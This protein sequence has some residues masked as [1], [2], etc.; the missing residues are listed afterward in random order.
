MELKIQGNMIQGSRDYQEDYYE[1]CTEQFKGLNS[2]LVVLCDGMGGHSGGALASHIVVTAFVNEFI[3]STKLTP[4]D[5]LAKSLSEAQLAIKAEVNDNAAPPDMGTTL[6]AIYV[7]DSDLHWLSVGDSHL[8]FYR[9][10][11]VI[12]LNED[13]SMA[14]VLDGLVEIGRLET[15]E[16]L[17]D[18]QRSAL[19]SY[20]SV[21][22][23]PLVDIQS[24]LNYLSSKDKLVLASDGLDTITLKDIE[25]I[26]DKNKNKSP[27]FISSKLLTA[28]EFAKAPNQDNASVVVVS[29]S[30]GFW[31]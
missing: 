11:E 15:E 16:A 19:R 23:I 13:H 18:P 21:D 14:A 5:A 25:T 27:D 22:D 4:S 7:S 9:K 28:V 26:I 1:I 30:K 24:K 12:K 8:Y 6:V 10:G 17:S 2:C 29:L 3:T 31:F 20:V